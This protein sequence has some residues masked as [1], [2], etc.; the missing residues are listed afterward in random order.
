MTCD[1]FRARLDAGSNPPSE[2]HAA[3]CPDCAELLWVRDRLAALREA[4]DEA[5]P[6]FEAAARR[7]LVAP[8][9]E[10]ARGSPILWAAAAVLALALPGLWIA[11][12][13]SPER[14]RIESG[15]VVEGTTG[16]GIPRAV[17]LRAASRGLVLRTPAG[18]RIRLFP[19]ARFVFEGER[20]LSLLE[21]TMECR[22]VPGREPAFVAVVPGG[23]IEG[24][25]TRFR[26]ETMK[27]TMI[28]AVLS[29]SVIF[30]SEDGG[31]RQVD[32]GRTL[33][34]SSGVWTLQ[35][36]LDEL[37]RRLGD[38]DF[39]T[40]EAAQK[41]LIEM[42]A[43]N[44]PRLKA[45]LKETKDPEIQSRLGQIIRML[46]P[47]DRVPQ[48]PK[49]QVR[50]QSLPARR[51]PGRGP[52]A[53]NRPSLPRLQYEEIPRPEDLEKPLQLDKEKLEELE[54]IYKEFD[55]RRDE[56]QKKLD[57]MRRGFE[58]RGR[59]GPQGGLREAW[60]KW[61]E[62]SRTLGRLPDDLVKRVRKALDEEQAKKFDEMLKELRE[63]K[64]KEQE[65][66]LKKLREQY[67][68]IRE[69]RH[70]AGGRAGR[71][72]GDERNEDDKEQ[73]RRRQGGS[74]SRGSYRE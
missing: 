39:E 33:R 10:P 19:E 7:A 69:N 6:E 66:R 14:A 42:G 67:R 13:G 50:G 11:F 73:N 60:R 53:P 15:G 36:E 41:R 37:I 28:L 9:A 55:E 51:I 32:E 52:E 54:K 57:A 30:A 22:V 1:E 58:K 29:G 40:R 34:V 44:L 70:R 35:D 74:S 59:A 47:P 27:G 62:L 5:Y 12:S 16:R 17:P 18:D 25:G 31:R 2:R 48:P 26:V 43:K 3:S 56:I 71:E 49:P 72:W 20:R 46:E 8:E 63:E 68:R 24:S 23:R 21:G 45:A 64:R 61:G 4:R 65:A 38:E